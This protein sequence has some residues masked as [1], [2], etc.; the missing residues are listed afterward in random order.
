MHDMK[1]R[2]CTETR[3][4]IKNETTSKIEKW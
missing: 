4:C 2:S 1:T 3:S